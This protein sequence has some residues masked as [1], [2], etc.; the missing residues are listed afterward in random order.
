M[1]KKG[2]YVHTRP[3]TGKIFH[4]TQSL[5]G[6]GAIIE[7]VTGVGSGILINQVAGVGG[8]PTINNLAAVPLGDVGVQ[9]L[10][11][12]LICAHVL[13]A[14]DDEHIEAYFVPSDMLDLIYGFTYS[15]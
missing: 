8:V 12:V 13:S 4:I 1:V 14:E 11:G 15:Y 9:Q 2:V 6:A 7:N 5:N 3:I 10:N